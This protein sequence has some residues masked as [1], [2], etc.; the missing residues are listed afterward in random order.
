MKAKNYLIVGAGR[1][2]IAAGKMLLEL[3]ER[4]T[5]YDGNSSLD[6]EAVSK[7]I[8][9]SRDIPFLLGDINKSDLKSFDICVVSPGVPLDTPIMTAVKTTVC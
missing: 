1:S 9:E 3:G 5:V 6:T 4:F 7:Q 2:G 8:S